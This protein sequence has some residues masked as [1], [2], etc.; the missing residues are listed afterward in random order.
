LKEESITYRDRFIPKDAWTTTV[1][2]ASKF[3]M[4]LLSSKPGLSTNSKVYVLSLI[5]ILN[6]AD[7]GSRVQEEMESL[8]LK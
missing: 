8:G 6:F 7:S 4:I 5:E 3:S 1:A 2:Y